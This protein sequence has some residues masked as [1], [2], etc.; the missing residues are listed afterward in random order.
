MAT[1]GRRAKD[2]PDIAALI[3]APR[4]ALIVGI[5][6]YAHGPWALTGA[7]E[8][9][10][11][12]ARLLREHFHYPE[13]DVIVLLDEQATRSGMVEGFR[14][15]RQK[16]SAAKNARVVVYFAGHGMATTDLEQVKSE[17]PG[18]FIP[19]DARPGAQD[20]YL[21]MRFAETKFE[22]LACHL[23]LLLLD[24]C[25]AGVFRWS[26]TRAAGGP[27]GVLY[28]ERFERFLRDPAWYVITSAAADERASDTLNGKVMLTGVRGE[29][30]RDDLSL[31]ARSPF[32]VALIEGLKSGDADSKVLDKRGDGVITA[33]EL[34]LYIEARFAQWQTDEGR[35]L[36]KPLLFPWPGN[37]KTKGEFVFFD[38]DGVRRLKSAIPLVRENNPYR[39]FLAYRTGDAGMFFGRDALTA[40]LHA[41]FSAAGPGPFVV[42]GSSGSGK[43]SLV[44]AGL[45]PLLIKAG[46]A[47]HVLDQPRHRPEEALAAVPRLLGDAAARGAPLL[48]V[49]DQLEEVARSDDLKRSFLAGIQRV[50]DALPGLRVLYVLRSDA[51]HQF[52]DLLR[53][54]D[55]VTNRLRVAPM[56]R[57]ELRLVIEGPAEEC[58]FRLDP[59]ALVDEIVEEIAYAPGALPLLSFTLSELYLRYVQAVERGG[60]SDRSLTRADYHQ[61]GGVTGCLATQADRVYAGLDA[62]AQATMRR[63][64]LRMVS[65]DT[66]KLARREVLRSELVYADARENERVDQVL[67][68]LVA[69]RLVVV[70]DDVEDG[71]DQRVVA[72]ADDRL[73]VTWGT[74][75]AWLDE[76]EV[77]ARFAALRVLSKRVPDW[78]HSQ[79]GGNLLHDDPRLDEWLALLGG[80]GDPFNA[81]EAALLRASEKQRADEIAAAKEQVARRRRLITGSLSALAVI[82]TVAAIVSASLYFRAEERAGQ[83]AITSGE[84]ATSRD[85]LAVKAEEAAASAR[86]AEQRARVARDT[87]RVVVARRIADEGSVSLAL[88]LLREVESSSPTSNVQGWSLGSSETLGL[89]G[90]ELVVLRGHD[91]GVHTA[92]YSKDGRHVLTASED[93]TARIWDAKSGATL[94]VL[95]G[96]ERP[97]RSAEWSLDERRV[98][99]LE[100][101]EPGSLARVWDAGTGRLLRSFPRVSSAVFAPDGDRIL[102]AS[103]VPSDPGAGTQIWDIET[104]ATLV[105]LKG[106]DRAVFSPDGGAVVTISAQPGVAHVWDA[107]T[108]K[109]RAILKDPGGQIDAAVF[110]P[111]GARIVTATRTDARVWNLATGQSTRMTLAVGKP[112]DFIY[113]PTFSPNGQYVLIPYDSHG[114][115]VC[116][117]DT[118]N[119]RVSIPDNAGRSGHLLLHAE[120]DPDGAHI[121]TSGEPDGTVRMWEGHTGKLV[122]A[123]RGH[124]THVNTVTFNSDGTRVLTASDD[125]TARIW[126]VESRAEVSV[127]TVRDKDV[128]SATFSPDGRRTLTVSVDGVQIWDAASGA[129]VARLSGDDTELSF[130]VP[131]ADW[132]RVVTVSSARPPRLW[133]MAADAPPIALDHGDTQ[134]GSIVAAVFSPD[135]RRLITMSESRAVWL[136]DAETGRTIVEHEG[137]DDPPNEMRA[138]LPRMWATFSPDGAQIATVTGAAHVQLL[139]AEQGARIATLPLKHVTD[140]RSITYDREGSR[141]FAV[142]YGGG[143]QTWDVKTREPSPRIRFVRSV[144]FSRDGKRAVSVWEAQDGG[145]VRIWDAAMTTPLVSL[146][147]PVGESTQAAFNPDGSRVMITGGR[148]V[149]LWDASSGAKLVAFAAR[150]AVNSAVVSPDGRRMLAASWGAARMWWTGAPG[151]DETILRLLWHATPICPSLEERMMHLGDDRPAAEATTRAC[152]AMVACIDDDSDDDQSFA[153]CLGA[154]RR[155]QEDP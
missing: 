52:H 136:W 151:D 46:W 130:A 79:R 32:T 9:A 144:D 152:E 50:A 121:V 113:T 23:L 104:G 27:P 84:L 10:Q 129:E 33:S 26:S 100:A 37:A 78:I 11:A 12:V 75:R 24:C 5:N 96:A 110:S 142:E 19:Q 86:K 147:T 118:G 155:S 107:A 77:K 82:L 97:L 116:Y 105:T 45:L 76:P 131:S 14:A 62:A 126:D 38:P 80:A 120:S 98:L 101:D 67:D 31:G 141:V 87:S 135:G 74:L 21:S 56:S 117:T 140:F 71:I 143:A 35:N 146:R 64:M 123:L 150:D 48:L 92:R 102:T 145:E 91:G 114:L 99:T 22:A 54:S 93:R 70:H 153:G 132:K 15:L 18:Y 138:V 44:A 72:P 20:T 112:V 8:D 16:I 68:A 137:V 4:F 81:D 47:C 25:F 139:D 148:E 65:L 133:N 66:G 127:F 30:E 89:P 51:E 119:Q 149:Q 57:D 90:R 39:G 13:D 83:L 42:L 40:D 1:I 124:R 3:H 103:S 88:G 73:I 109:L 154:F 53:T 94:V 128:T 58:V 115:V 122:A 60:R 6:R 69:A 7:A 28:K 108:R 125:A 134:P 41:K 106:A 61:L 85:D 49:V 29:H 63:V 95:R 36:Q 34:H 111:D 55:P 17:T 2:P 43:S 59:P